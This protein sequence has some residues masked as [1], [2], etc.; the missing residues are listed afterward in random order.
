MEWT[1]ADCCK[2][3]MEG[4]V[5]FIKKDMQDESRAA[6]YAAHALSAKSLRGDNETERRAAQPSRLQLGR[7]RL[8]MLDCADM[9]NKAVRH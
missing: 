2:Q 4:E 3:S 8:R 6:F 5:P 9:G 7:V 1:A